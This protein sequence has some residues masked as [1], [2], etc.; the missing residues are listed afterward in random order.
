MRALRPTFSLRSLIDLSGGDSCDGEEWI[1]PV[2]LAFILHLLTSI[3]LTPNLQSSSKSRITTTV[4]FDHAFLALSS[5][6]KLRLHCVSYTAT[7]SCFDLATCLTLSVKTATIFCS[8][9][10]A[11]L[12]PATRLIPQ[13][14]PP[15]SNGQ[16]SHVSLTD[17]VLYAQGFFSR[18][19][20]LHRLEPPAP[21]QSLRLR[22]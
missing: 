6:K 19:S 8:W 18:G 22:H 5:R 1:L 2:L 12:P 7:S 21:L 16:S 10:P 4:L 20:Q 15:P 13:A 3:S 17:P 11:H 9:R 14:Q